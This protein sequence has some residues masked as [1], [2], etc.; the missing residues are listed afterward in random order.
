MRKIKDKFEF[1]CQG[2][3]GIMSFEILKFGLSK[4]I[5]TKFR[6]IL[7]ELSEFGPFP[8]IRTKVGALPKG[9]LLLSCIPWNK[10]M[11]P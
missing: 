9:N 8:K 2:Y 4:Q 5:Q 7:E 11:C 1:C 6:L 3:Y 10:G